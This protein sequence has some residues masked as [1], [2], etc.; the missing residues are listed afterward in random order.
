MK[1][2]LI[3]SMAW[4]AVLMLF[5]IV[6][7]YRGPVLAIALVPLA[8]VIWYGAKPKLGSSRR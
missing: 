2:E 7:L 4:S 5:G 6:V 3:K 8:I 1:A